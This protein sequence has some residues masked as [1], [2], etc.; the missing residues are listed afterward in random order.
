MRRLIAL[1]VLAL[2][3]FLVSPAAAQLTFTALSPPC[4]V[5]DT[6]KPTGPTAQT[7][8]QPLQAGTS[9]TF[10]VQGNAGDNGSGGACAMAVPAGAVAVFLN[11]TAVVPAGVG[12]IRL[13]PAGPS[14]PSVSTINY[15]AG[16]TL[17]NG[18]I[19][20]LAATT[21][22][23]GAHV[24]VNGAHFVLDIAGYFTAAGPLR[25]Y[26]LDPCRAYD[27]RSAAGPTG[28]N[29]IPYHVAQPFTLQ[30]LCGIPVGAKAAVLTV[31]ALNPTVTGDLRVYP[32]TPMNPVFVSSLNFNAGEPAIANGV[33]MPLT[34]ATPDL[35]V[36]GDPNSTPPG[37][38]HVLIDVTGYF[39]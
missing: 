10:N 17:A 20:P 34:A 33:F 32:G 30:G 4:R 24:D 5:L 11:A 38:L 39:E 16:V 21:P 23:L 25:Y 36:Y 29:P 7:A 8:G 35:S 26:P 31:S 12:D 1:F 37:T 18:A 28:G 9:Y 13:Y 2:G 6:R 19:V 27:T 22:D 14:F 3:G 15:G